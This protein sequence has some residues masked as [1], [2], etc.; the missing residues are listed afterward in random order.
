MEQPGYLI[1]QSHTD[2]QPL[3][4]GAERSTV[5]VK[6]VS[7]ESPGRGGLSVVDYLP[8]AGDVLREG[9]ESRFDEVLLQ[10]LVLGVGP[11]GDV[12]P[13]STRDRRSGEVGDESFAQRRCSLP[14]GI[15]GLGLFVG[16]RAA[17]DTHI[18]K[19][20]VK[21]AVVRRQRTDVERLI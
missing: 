18:L 20:T 6:R 14:V 17:P 13:D 16:Q 3:E 15:Q 5:G 21:H 12:P 2:L 4:L 8:R 7:L 11:S 9:I 10:S 19:F 1:I